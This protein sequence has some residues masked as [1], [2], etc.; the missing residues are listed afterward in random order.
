M[1]ISDTNRTISMCN[2]GFTHIFGYKQEEVVGNDTS[3]IYESEEEFLRMGEMRFNI[4]AKEQYNSEIGNYRRKNGE[5]FPAEVVGAPFKDANGM[6]LGF[7]GVIRDITERRQAEMSLRASE[8]RFR[9]L[10]ELSSDWYWEQD[11]SFRFTLMSEGIT[12]WLGVS[13]NEHIGRTRWE[14]PYVD[15][16]DDVWS[17]HKADLKAHR[18]FYNLELKRIDPQGQIHY[19]TNTGKPIFGTTGRFKGYRGVATDVTQRKHAEERIEH[20]APNT[21]RRKVQ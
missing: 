7:I 14:L 6:T 16:P 15:V 17:Q 2:F 21:N 4:S 5:V 10:T 19:I 1:I 18:S 20:L 11:D 3:I 12:K 13:V 8:E 9:S